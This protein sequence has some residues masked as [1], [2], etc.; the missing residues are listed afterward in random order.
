MEPRRRGPVRACR[1]RGSR[2]AKNSDLPLKTIADQSGY[3][4][5]AAFSRAFKC[6]FG[7]PPG[8]WRRRQA[9]RG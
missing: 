9:Q 1:W 8:D 2:T 5:E 6:H 7:L 4:S 3:E